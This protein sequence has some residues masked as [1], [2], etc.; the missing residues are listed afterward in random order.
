MSDGEFA[1]IMLAWTLAMGLMYWPL[2]VG[3]AGELWRLRR[4]NTRG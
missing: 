4:K 3:L 2:F 1:C